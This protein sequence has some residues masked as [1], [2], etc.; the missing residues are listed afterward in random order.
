MRLTES[1]PDIGL[2]NQGRALLK[3]KKTHNELQVLRRTEK[4][5]PG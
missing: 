5:L 3:E 2:Q 1:E 4:D